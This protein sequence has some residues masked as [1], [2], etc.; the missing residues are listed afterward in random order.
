MKVPGKTKGDG[1]ELKTVYVI[2]NLVLL[3]KSRSGKSK[4]LEA[5][6]IILKSSMPSFRL[7]TAEEIPVVDFACLLKQDDHG[8]RQQDGKMFCQRN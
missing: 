2:A 7:L 5:L 1:A 8:C 4:S 3:T 6:A